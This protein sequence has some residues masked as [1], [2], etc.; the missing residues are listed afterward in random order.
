MTDFRY[1]LRQLLRAP[2]FALIAIVSLAL[3][4]GANTA[5][6][7]L[8]NA[9]LFRPVTTLRADEVV[10]IY[11]G[12]HS[13]LSYGEFARLQATPLGL[14]QV[15]GERTL[16]VGRTDGAVPEGLTGSIVV[17][18]YFALLGARP[19][20]GRLFTAADTSAA[21]A[22]IVVLSHEYWRSRFASDPAV[23]GRVI[24][25]NGQAYTIV[26][27]APDGFTGSMAVW[28]PALF[29]PL[30]AVT[31]LM[32]IG[33]AEWGGSIYTIGRVAPGGSRR[34][35]DAALQVLGRRL[36]AEDSARW[37]GEPGR[38]VLRAGAARGLTEELR[39]PTAM[40]A[41][42]LL[43]LVALVL[44]IACANVA[45][46]LLA[47]ATTRARE[48][49]VR[50]ALGARRMRLVRQLL[51]ESLLLAFGG[52]LLAVGTSVLVAGR[53][54]AWIVAK[55]P[56]PVSFDVSMDG[57]V[58]GYTAF[59][60]T[61]AVL[62]FGLVPALRASR[63]DLAQVLRDGARGTDRRG[64][65]LRTLLVGGQVAL[66]T[67]V[68][69]TAA[70]FTRSLLESRHADPGFPARGV[71]DM[72]VNV[73]TRRLAPAAERALLERVVERARG[74]PG[75]EQVSLA[76]TVPLGGS[77]ME[78]GIL[79][80]PRTGDEPAR[81]ATD[82][83]IVGEDYF[84]TL[85]IP[86]VR[87][88]EFGR[89]ERVGPPTAIVVNETFA[90]RMWPGEDAIGRRVSI[91]GAEG[92]WLTVV[93]V[94]RDIRYNSLGE[95][96]TPM[97]YQPWGQ[98]AGGEMVLHART[99]PT[100]VADVAVELSRLLRDV[101]PLLPPVQAVPIARDMGNALMMAQLG[102]VL[103][104]GFGVLAMLLASVGIYG[105]TTFAVAQRTREIGIR[106]ALGAA[107][108]DVVRLVAARTARPVASGL[109]VGLVLATGVSFLVR[110]Q[111][112]GVGAGDPLAL[113][114][115]ALAIAAVAALAAWAPVRRATRLDP[116]RALAAE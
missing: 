67:I 94:A 65:R 111:L 116:S 58:L 71:V 50:A 80:E 101:D 25:V 79:L 55:A 108:D 61:V 64:S 52:G 78:R 13:P 38:P 74:I 23:A 15:A 26:G 83:N 109:L 36:V 37:G 7:S 85:G 88:R 93:G 29:F 49:G 27:V 40:G 63:P 106:I 59:L 5:V 6:F 35:V 107:R 47:R 92:P 21:E 62:A 75:V 51:A 95:E 46:L 20:L 115:T 22:A 24:R 110:A 90:A 2:G 82:F 72:A 77:R 53:V 4:V 60:C 84:A 54:S 43:V 66:C 30:P 98:H 103:L 104:G 114:G 44:L 96:P 14:A 86:L 17:G 41:S 102:A 105:I 8:A 97:L 76:R 39:G 31:P 87:G 10:R 42:F 68:L 73:E 112:Y 32:G 91:E 113:V 34:Q 69:A 45:N 11:R 16:R 56:E 33:L 70:L 48:L 100:R 9:L 28:R 3:G 19:A 12:R 99:A 1:A 18:D 81:R 89:E 57:R